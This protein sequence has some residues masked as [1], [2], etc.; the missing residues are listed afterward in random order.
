MQNSTLIIV[1][2]ACWRITSLFVHEAGPWDIFS[3]LREWAGLE[4]DAAGQVIDSRHKLLE[5]LA[6]VWCLSLWIGAALL[7]LYLIG[8]DNLLV[9]VS[10]PFALSMG[11]IIMER[12]MG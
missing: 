12:L 5:V 8:G 3:R 6:C 4:Y 2:L 9:A 11:S 7:A 10:L 1:I